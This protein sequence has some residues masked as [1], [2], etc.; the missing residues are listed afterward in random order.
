MNQ[1]SII[2]TPQQVKYIRRGFQPENIA[3]RFWLKVAITANDKKCW[4]WTASKL[5]F[6]YG[7]FQVYGKRKSAHK[8]SYE[9][10]KGEVPNGLCVLH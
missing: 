6:G 7:N 5:P 9:L 8:F 3:K 4:N 1:Y 2:P 10:N